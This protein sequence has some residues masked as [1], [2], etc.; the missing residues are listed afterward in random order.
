MKTIKNI[1]FV[2]F[3]VSLSSCSND[4]EST[5]V[6]PPSTGF[7]WTENGN[8]T[9]LTVDNP[10]VNAPYNTIYAVRNGVTIYE[11]NLT[12]L[13]PGTYSF[14][15]N[16]NAI[17]YNNNASAGSFT[18]T[19]G[20]VIITANANNKISGTFTATGSGNGVSSLSGQFTDINVT[21]SNP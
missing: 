7:T 21:T 3:L 11:F 17:Y 1:L 5:P 16:A 15:G 9:V 6:T 8:A 18:A 14:S 4:D 12:S 19:G 13:A 2:L 10:N 20:S